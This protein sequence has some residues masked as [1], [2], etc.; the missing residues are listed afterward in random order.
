[1]DVKQLKLLLGIKLK[2]QLHK[3]SPEKLLYV[4]WSVNKNISNHIFIGTFSFKMNCS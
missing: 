1:M 4:L 2:I 3:N